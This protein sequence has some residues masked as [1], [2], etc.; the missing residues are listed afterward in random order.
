VDQFVQDKLELD[1]ESEFEMT[2]EMEQWIVE[3]A[4]EGL[5]SGPAVD[6]REYLDELVRRTSLGLPVRDHRDVGK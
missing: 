5:K 3:M 2:D 4:E 6:A 1:D